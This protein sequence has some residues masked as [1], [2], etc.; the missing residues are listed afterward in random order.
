MS[1]KA[2]EGWKAIAEMFNVS[3]RVMINRK[4]E[5]KACGAIF[6]MLKGDPSKHKRHRVVCAFP[7]QLKDWMMIKSAKGEKF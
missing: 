3:V 5:L 4:T 2:I 7:S 1:E 6:Y